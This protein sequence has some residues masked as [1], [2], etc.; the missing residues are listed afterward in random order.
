MLLD[1]DTFTDDRWL[2]QK[3]LLRQKY[4][5]RKGDIIESSVITVSW[6]NFE[7]GGNSKT[8]RLPLG[9]RPSSSLAAGSLSQ[10]H[11]L[12]LLWTPGNVSLQESKFQLVDDQS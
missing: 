5:Q 10:A 9:L 7:R 3:E 11:L 8:T 1:P 6:L 2:P 12:S 4:E